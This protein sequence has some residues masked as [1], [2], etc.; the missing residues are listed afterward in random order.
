MNSPYFVFA[1]TSRPDDN[2]GYF[3]DIQ[4]LSWSGET[5]PVT[6]VT[7]ERGFLFRARPLLR[8]VQG[9]RRGLSGSWVRKSVVGV[10]GRNETRNRSR[11]NRALSHTGCAF[12]KCVCHVSL[13]P[14]W[15]N[16]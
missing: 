7:A 1:L 14:R 3:E 2:V 9:G 8:A 11:G 13:G 10:V 5:G 15:I 6:A 4:D 12:T 16:R